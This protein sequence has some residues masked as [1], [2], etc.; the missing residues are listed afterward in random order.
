M[1]LKVTKV[2][3]KE[4]LALV[5]KFRKTNSGRESMKVAEEIKQKVAE[6][7]RVS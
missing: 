2:D 3:K 6:M 4:L 7:K 5:D 1:G